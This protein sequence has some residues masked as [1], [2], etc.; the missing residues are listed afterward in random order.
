MAKTITEW[1]QEIINQ[2]QGDATLAP[3]LTSTSATA[4]WRLFAYVVATAI[5]TVDQLFTVHKTDVSETIDALKPHSLRWY[6]EKAKE[7]QYGYT[8]PD[9]TDTYNNTGIADSLIEASLIVSYAAVVEQTR[10][11]RI[12]VAKTSGSDLAALSSPELTAFEAYMAAV[13]DAGVKLNITSTAADNLKLATRIKYNP[14]IIKSD[15][16]RLDGTA[17]TPV[18]DAIRTFLKNLPFNGVFSIQKLVDAIQAVEGVADVAIDLCQTQYGA[19][20]FTTVNIDY[21]PDSG[22]LVLLDG[23][24]SQTNI[25]A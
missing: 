5:W 24:Y 18:K 11:I 14:Q 12:K 13:K 8:L 16:S 20:A 3:I 25:A 2:V 19:L 1:Q 17:A 15:G 21:T 10:G 23:N 7:F 6:A 22:Y 9:D 4:I